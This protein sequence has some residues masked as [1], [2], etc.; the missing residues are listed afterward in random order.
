MEDAIK[1]KMAQ[2]A[3]HDVRISH[4]EAFDEIIADSTYEV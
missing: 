1:T 4:E 2:Y 3:R